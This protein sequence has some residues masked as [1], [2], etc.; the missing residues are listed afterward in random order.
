MGVPKQR[1]TKSRRNKRR[2]HLKIKPIELLKCP[3]CGESVLPHHYCSGCGFYNGKEVIDVLAKLSKRE[4]KRVQRE[5]KEKE[6]AQTQKG[7]GLSMEEMSR[8]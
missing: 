2:A 1:Q 7:K 6:R 3:K 4:R 5:Q 8:K